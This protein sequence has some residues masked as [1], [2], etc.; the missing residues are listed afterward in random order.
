MSLKISTGWKAFFYL[1]ISY[2]VGVII[3]GYISYL[4]DKQGM[5]ENIDA[6]LRVAAKSATLILGDDYHSTIFENIPAAKMNFDA[7][8]PFLSDFAKSQKVRYVY[9]LVVMNGKIYFAS[10]SDSDAEVMAGTNA[11]FMEEYLSAPK[12]LVEL[13]KNGIEKEIFAE[14][15]DK[16]GSFR[17][18]FVLKKMQDGHLYIAGADVDKNE[19]LNLAYASTLNV[20]KT[21]LFYLL[22]AL[23]AM[24]FYVRSVKKNKHEMMRHFFADSLTGFGNRFAL[25]K[26]IG[27]TKPSALMLLNIDSFREINDFYGHKAGDNVLRQVSNR[28]SEFIQKGFSGVASGV[29]LYKLHADEFGVLFKDKITKEGLE[30]V[31]EI[32]VQHVSSIPIIVDGHELI[33]N[34]T[35]GISLADDN[36]HM[37]SGKYL[38]TAANIAL[39]EAKLAKRPFMFYDESMH[40]EQKYE[41]NLI[42]LG[43]L[44]NALADDKILPYY[45]PILDNKTGKI[46]KYECLVRLIDD[47]GKV[48]SP[49]FFLDIA[50]KSRLYHK[51]TKIVVQKAFQKFAGTSYSFSINLSVLDICDKEMSEFILRKLATSGQGENVIFEIVESE[52]IDSYEEVFAFVEKV[53]AYGSKIS[54]DDFGAGY[55]NFDHV[56][57]LKPNYI[58]IDGSLIKNIDVDENARIIA[59]SIVG[60][61]NELGAKSVAEFVHS[62]A[63]LDTVIGLRIDYSQGYHISAPV[64]DLLPNSHF[65]KTENPHS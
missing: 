47:D 44:K 10:T 56:L 61:A 22:L 2:V 9:T 45:Q 1:C 60:F 29:S 49:Y 42:W 34:A 25:I 19:L 13:A 40:I 30:F 14:Y 59:K 52:G 43:K 39:K 23:P 54:I 48:V 65:S 7:L 46:V 57:R 50:K 26:K 62:Q 32:L 15:S 27:E 18:V 38:M 24:F 17:S 8:R 53:K 35:A 4:D 16:W 11:K 6:R 55:S 36:R 58:K 21:S 37:E 12:E 31:A 63:V 3:Y 20:I 51:I 5:Q 41:Q 33:V 64:A 28:L